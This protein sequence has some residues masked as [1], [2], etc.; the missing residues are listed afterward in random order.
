MKIPVLLVF[1]LGAC[2]CTTK[3]INY[4]WLPTKT[5][6]AGR[7]YGT[8]YDDL[9]V[10]RVQLSD[11]GKGLIGVVYH[12]NAPA[13]WPITS[14][15]LHERV[16]NLKLENRSGWATDTV[17]TARVQGPRLQLHAAGP[18]GTRTVVLK[19]EDEFIR[20]FELLRRDMCDPRHGSLGK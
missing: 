8:A 5:E 7:W 18:T 16:V 19:R 6:L 11:N 1:M 9:E 12:T 10:W 13:L 17:F 14:W 4:A 15:D 20:R 2:G 3:C